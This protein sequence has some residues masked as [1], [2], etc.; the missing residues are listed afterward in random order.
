LSLIVV[1]HDNLSIPMQDKQPLTHNPFAALKGKLGDLPPGPQPAPMSSEEG[2]VPTAKVNGKCIVRRERSGRG[3]KA[4]TLVE[5]PALE[6]RDLEA[7]AQGLK[8]ALGTGARV[9]ASSVV[10]QGDQ[11]DRIVDWLRKQGFTE[12]VRGN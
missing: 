6:G 4:V 3:G 5:G 2:A 1:R 12:I 11:P 8:R 9:E 10:V 7:M